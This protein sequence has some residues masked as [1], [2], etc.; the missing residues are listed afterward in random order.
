MPWKF[1]D[2]KPILSQIE[3]AEVWTQAEVSPESVTPRDLEAVESALEQAINESAKPEAGGRW[4]R[5]G[6]LDGW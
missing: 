4:G 3:T 5:S 6:V 2:D 1:G